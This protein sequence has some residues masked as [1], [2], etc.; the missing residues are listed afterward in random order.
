MVGI[1]WGY[2]TAGIG[3]LRNSPLF[4]PVACAVMAVLLL[5]FG[6]QLGFSTT[7]TYQGA[8]LMLMLFAF[9][10]ILQRLHL[11]QWLQVFLALGLGCIVLYGAGAFVF[12]ATRTGPPAPTKY[13]FQSIPVTVGT[14][15]VMLTPANLAVGSPVGI[16]ELAAQNKFWEWVRDGINWQ[17]LGPDGNESNDPAS[18]PV[19]L[20]AKSPFSGLHYDIAGEINLNDNLKIDDGVTILKSMQDG[21]MVYRQMTCKPSRGGNDS[22]ATFTLY[23]PRQGEEVL[24]ILRVR[25]KDGQALHGNPNNYGVNL[26]V[27]QQ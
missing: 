5:A 10:I 12:N 20:E 9:A 16:K 2:I 18:R 25:T 26:R 7:E 11:P 14:P 17:P 23:G 19:V 8:V 22:A 13:G 4:V 6:K 1:L 15:E 3:W 21:R 27:N 24:M